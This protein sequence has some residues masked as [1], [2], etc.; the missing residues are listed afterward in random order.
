M[1]VDAGRIYQILEAL[2]VSRWGIGDL[3]GCPW[4]VAAGYNRSV[5]LLVAYEYDLDGYD[6]AAFHQLL[7][8]KQHIATAAVT[9]LCE[10]FMGSGVACFPVPHTQDQRLLVSTFSHKYAATRAGLGWIGRNSLLV[11][12]E[13]G[14][15][16]FLR[17]V[18]FDLAMEA[19]EPVNESRC[20]DCT[21]CVEA[22]P[23]ACI[24]GVEWKPGMDR[25]QLLDVFTCNQVRLDAIPTL[26]HK[27]ACGF[28]LLA[29]PTG[30]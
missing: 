28:C 21:A 14:P 1:E 26:G 15:R 7:L 9:E 3:A 29:C 2:P 22:C 18:L 20:G 16:V 4:P 6:E 30:R 23:C 12:P 11:T 10:A 24:H 27:D 5:S 19:A 13:W 25:D 17:T 8:E